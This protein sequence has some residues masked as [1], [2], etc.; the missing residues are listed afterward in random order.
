MQGPTVKLT[1][2]LSMKFRLA[3]NSCLSLQSGGIKGVPGSA[4][5]SCDGMLTEFLTSIRWSHV[6]VRAERGRGGGNLQSVSSND[7]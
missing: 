6:C 5:H 4:E 2:R 3:F 7:K 1:L